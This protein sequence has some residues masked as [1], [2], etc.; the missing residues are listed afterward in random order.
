VKLRFLQAIPLI[1]VACLFAVL[2]IGA[3]LAVGYEWVR[4][5]FN[6]TECHAEQVALA[7]KASA[8]ANRKLTQ[9]QAAIERSKQE[10]AW[11]AANSRVAE[12]RSELDHLDRQYA[13]C[14]A[15][16]LVAIDASKTVVRLRQEG[17]N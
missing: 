17:F 5:Q 12:L 8:A 16:R 10:I 3:P 14:E 15:R 13:E 9:C 2:M 7:D 4:C 1:V 6:Q 11:L